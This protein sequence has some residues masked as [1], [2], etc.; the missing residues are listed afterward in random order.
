MDLSKLKVKI[1]CDA[2]DLNVMDDMLSQ[3]LVTGF[4][5]NPSICRKAGVTNYLGFCRAAAA[6]FPNHPLSL[7]VIADDIG[8]MYRQALI[9]SE[10]GPNVYVKIPCVNSRG[11]GNWP[12]IHD[13]SLNGV[14]VNIT[15]VFTHK[16]IHESFA[17][18]HDVPACV[19]VFAGR[20]SDA[21]QCPLPYVQHAIHEAAGTQTEVIWASVPYHHRFPGNAPQAKVVREEP[22][23]VFQ[24]DGPDVCQ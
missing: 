16:Q 15:C 11:G 21:G 19:S 9:L 1:F 12:V 4:T 8:E 13:L 23:R 18:L 2:A 6:L 7:E 14:K 5:S 20:I 22:G 3:G 10:L 24:G 17:N